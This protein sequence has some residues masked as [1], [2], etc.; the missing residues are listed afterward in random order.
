MRDRLKARLKAIRT[1]LA[2]NAH[3]VTTICARVTEIAL[4]PR[5]REEVQ[6]AAGATNPY[7][8]L[9][10]IAHDLAE[11]EA[12]LAELANTAAAPPDLC[13]NQI[14]GAPRPVDAM[15]SS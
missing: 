13:G 4:D 6:R 8:A 11:V 14:L 3:E 7:A 2:E 9:D 5:I 15:F 12:E 10:Q 1:R